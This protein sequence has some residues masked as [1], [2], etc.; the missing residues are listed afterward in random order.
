MAKWRF[1][2]P[3]KNERKSFA[4]RFPVRESKAVAMLAQN[5]RELRTTLELSQ[6]ALAALVDVDQTEISKIEL[7]RGNPTIIFVE[8]LA[9]ALGVSIEDLLESKPGTKSVRP[10]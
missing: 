5:L 8:R 3:K 6:A 1:L 2:V 9:A 7:Q 10:N 4:A